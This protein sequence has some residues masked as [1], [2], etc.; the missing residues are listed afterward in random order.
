MHFIF[1]KE[2]FPGLPILFIIVIR[3]SHICSDSAVI[4]EAYLIHC[5]SLGIS[6]E[7]GVKVDVN[8]IEYLFGSVHQSRIPIKVNQA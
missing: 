7:D 1:D 8:V 4:T 6:H 2:E 5:V 3:N